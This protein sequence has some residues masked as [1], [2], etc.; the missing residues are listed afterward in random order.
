MSL[1]SLFGP[2]SIEVSGNLLSTMLSPTEVILPSLAI[3]LGYAGVWQLAE[4]IGKRNN[5]E[6]MKSKDYII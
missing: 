1:E 6:K 3:A 4:Y 2:E 5:R